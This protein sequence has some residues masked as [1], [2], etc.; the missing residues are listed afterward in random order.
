MKIQQCIKS[1]FYI[2]TKFNKAP[3]SE[4]LPKEGLFFCLHSK[5]KLNENDEPVKER[6]VGEVLKEMKEMNEPI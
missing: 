1:L 3:R 6:T 5:Y 2:T 4:S